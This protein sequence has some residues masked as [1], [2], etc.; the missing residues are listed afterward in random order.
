MAIESTIQPFSNS[1]TMLIVFQWKIPFKQ[2]TLINNT[3]LGSDHL[4]YRGEEDFVYFIFFGG[5]GTCYR[6]KLICPSNAEVNI[7]TLQFLNTKF[8]L[9]LY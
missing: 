5:G 6:N 3:S 8:L 2:T 1:M 9:N 4:T 7:L